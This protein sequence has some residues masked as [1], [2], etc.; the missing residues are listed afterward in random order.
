MVIII[1]NRSNV[2][3]GWGGFGESN[4]IDL[5]IKNILIFNGS[6][7]R[8]EGYTKKNNI[9]FTGITNEKK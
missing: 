2:Y 7:R 6:Q 1:F 5:Y 4:Y 3:V 8:N 9:K